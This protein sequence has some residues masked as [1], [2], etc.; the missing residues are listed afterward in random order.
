MPRSIRPPIGQSTAKSLFPWR[1]SKGSQSKVQ[2]ETAFG[3]PDARVE[4]CMYVGSDPL[5][6][7]SSA[8][9]LREPAR[10][11]RANGDCGKLEVE[12]RDR[13]IRL[14]FAKSAASADAA[15]ACSGIEKRSL[16]LV[17]DRRLDARVSQFNACWMA[18]S[19]SRRLEY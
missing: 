10:A 17:A 12:P 2:F 13:G 6:T 18:K 11:L 5:S 1:L 19:L 3:G 7:G 4:I 8:K 15:Q 9:V 16:F 14:I